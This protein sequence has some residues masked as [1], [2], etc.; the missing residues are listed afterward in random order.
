MIKKLMR[1]IR[2]Y[3]RDT[4]LSPV[5]VTCEVILEVLI[6]FLMAKLIDNGIT[7]GDMGYTIRMGL[8][9]LVCAAASLGF[10]ALSGLAASHAHTALCTP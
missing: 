2:E 8:V 3:K 4:I 1:S 5:F 6:P 10:G 9:L 7:P